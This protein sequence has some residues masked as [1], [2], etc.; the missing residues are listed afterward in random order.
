MPGQQHAAH[1][2]TPP[3][4]SLQRLPGF[5]RKTGKQAERQYGED[6]AAENDDRRRRLGQFA[7]DA[8]QAEEQCADM[9][10]AEG[11]A[12]VHGDPLRQ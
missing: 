8:S 2:Q 5:L 12:M 1:Q 6:R 7:E 4:L 9:Q 3:V 11:G 10:G